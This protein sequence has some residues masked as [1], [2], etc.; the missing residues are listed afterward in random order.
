LPIRSSKEFFVFYRMLPTRSRSHKR[1]TNRHLRNKSRRQLGGAGNG[2]KLFEAI[3]AGETDKVKSMLE[4]D[5]N[6]L[7]SRSGEIV[8]GGITRKGLSPLTAACYAEKIDLIFV[9]IHELNLPDVRVLELAF[10]KDSQGISPIEISESNFE[11]WPFKERVKEMLYLKSEEELEEQIQKN[12]K[13]EMNG[14]PKLTRAKAE[15]IVRNRFAENAVHRE[16]L[17]DA[18][19]EYKLNRL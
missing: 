13:G 1:K 11:L 19:D 12:I 6:L 4:K 15:K 2:P 8:I 9:I 10:E 17:N 5:I 18:E 14:N 7:N 16:R 3:I